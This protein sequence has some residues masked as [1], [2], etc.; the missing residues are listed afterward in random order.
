MTALTDMVD[1]EV[2]DGVG[3]ITVNNPP[4]NALSQGV[5]QGLKEGIEK[6]LGDDAVQAALIICEGRTYIAGADITE[7]GKPPQE[8]G[9]HGVLDTMEAAGKPVVSAIHGTALGGGLETALS[10]H[11]RVADGKARF[12]LPEVKLGLLPGAGGT[13]RLPRI[14]GV[15]KALDMVTTGNMVGAKEALANGL[16]DEIVDDLKAGGI[17]FAKKIAAG[18]KELVKV[19]DMNEKLESA[20]ANPSLFDDYRK[21]NAK[22][23][24]GFEAPE[25]N[26]K[27]IEAAVN[28]TFD[29]GM[30][31]ER[32]EFMKLMTGNQSAAQRYFFFAEREAAKIPDIGKDVA[33]IPV[34]KVAVIGG[35]TMGGGISMNFANAGIPVTMVEV[36]DEALERG[37]G[38][39]RRNYENTAK[40]GRMT[41]EQV[42]QRMSIISGATS[43]ETIGD[44][45]MVIEAVFENMDL[46]KAIFAELD[47][48]MKPGAILA[49]NT[50]AL[51]VNEIASA[52]KRPEA[53][54]GTHFFSPA[55]VMKLVEVVRGDATSKEVVKT[56]MS[57][58]KKI[59]KV[60]VQCGVCHGFIG[61][62]MLYGRG[63]QANKMILEGAPPQDVDKVIFD[64]GFPMGPFA[65]SDL[66][67]LDIGWNKDTTSSST[68]REI[69]CEMD[70]RGQ[71]TSAGFYDYKPGDRTPVPNAEVQAIITKFAED[72]QITQRDVS[73]QEILER[74][75]FPMVNEG[76]K[77]LE[78]GIANRA[79]DID[80]VWIYGYGWPIFTGG[81]MFWAD[82]YGLDKL[83]AKMKEYQAQHGDE[84]K[85]AKLIEDLVAEG[86]SFKDFAA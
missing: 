59:G 35:G 21:K 10:C 44:C 86:K 85:P 24:R 14:M 9:L 4:V 71:K 79:S 61:N 56:C 37:I 12:G 31:F 2:T 83:L 38:I 34:N 63:V 68:V 53:V 70:R 18:N 41:Q 62:R 13:Q 15:E 40:K 11:Y 45:D 20:R 17:A 32:D 50:S 82:S 27:C 7:F 43:K 30:K 22:R 46:K 76:A 16:I 36:S 64:F 75:L 72:R 81:P 28:M 67:G 1:Y 54:I 5:R 74:C 26:I 55:N 48:I 3:V 25:A 51:D 77:I 58:S 78:E 80:V 39:I 29:D 47:G 8:P 49:S 66:A 57:L 33:E 19:R 84:F 52:T 6:A 65:M 60:A 69:L 23:M 73:D 42:E